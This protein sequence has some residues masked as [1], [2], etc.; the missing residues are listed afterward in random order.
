L[1]LLVDCNDFIA[2]ILDTFDGKDVLLK[3][4]IEEGV[5]LIEHNSVS[6]T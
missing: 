3:G 4:L 2:S 6:S 1:H 5:L